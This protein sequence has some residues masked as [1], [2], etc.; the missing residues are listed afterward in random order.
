MGGITPRVTIQHDWKGQI[1]LNKV[2]GARGSIVGGSAGRQR[3]AVF[4]VGKHVGREICGRTAVCTELSRLVG[5]DGIVLDDV[6]CK[7]ATH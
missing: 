7:R 3:L 1:A 6:L 4:E 2:V 5:R